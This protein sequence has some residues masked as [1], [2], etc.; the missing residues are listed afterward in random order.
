MA[1][2]PWLDEVRRRLAKHALPPSYIQR[3][4]EELSDHLE[5]F[6]EENM[7]TEADVCSRLGEPEQVAKAAVVAYRRRSFLGRHPTAAFL[8]FAVSPV[9]TLIATALVVYCTFA[10]VCVVLWDIAFIDQLW[11]IETCGFLAWGVTTL[12][13]IVI[14]SILVSFLYCELAHYLGIG[15]KWIFAACSVLAALAGTVWWCATPGGSSS[16]NSLNILVGFH[17]PLQLVQFIIPLVIGWLFVRR[18]REQTYP[19]MTFF[20]FAPSPVVAFIILWFV[21]FAFLGMAAIG[22]GYGGD[23]TQVGT[24]GRSIF[25]CVMAL[26]T[27]ILPAVLLCALYGRAAKR[28]RAKSK[29]A[30]VSCVLLATLAG[31]CHYQLGPVDSKLC[32]DFGFYSIAQLSQFLVPLAIGLW[33]VRRTRD[34]GRLQ[35]AS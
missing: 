25:L 20:V 4:V 23:F 2:Q 22:L 33:F 35:L 13:S 14:P 21:A 1:N 10:V 12:V 11:Q 31:A 19:T 28:V 30:Y 3:F 29:W 5:D 27:L 24:A 15:R 6:K 26:A 17:N 9:A 7:G 16:I 34:H 18:K 32:L 8:V